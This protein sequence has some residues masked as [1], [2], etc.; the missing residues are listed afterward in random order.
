[1][2]FMCSSTAASGRLL[3]CDG[4]L[5][6]TFAAAAFFLC[7]PVSAGGVHMHNTVLC[8]RI[9]YKHVASG[10]AVKLFCKADRA[11]GSSCSIWLAVSPTLLL[12]TWQ[13]VMVYAPHLLLSPLALAAMWG[14]H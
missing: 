14:R 7:F 8:F 5:R 11:H 13:Q 1:M 2:C 6:V 12:C 9:E 10:R 3:R 4:L